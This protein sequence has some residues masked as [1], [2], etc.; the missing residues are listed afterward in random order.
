MGHFSNGTEGE[1]YQEHYCFRCVHWNDDH[2]CP[3]WF[4]HELHVGEK[5]W[6][7]T[8][9]KLIPMEPKTFNGITIEF[10]GKC[11]TFQRNDQPIEAPLRPGQEAA[12]KEWRNGKSAAAR[13][14][15]KRE[16]TTH[17]L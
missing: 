15:A 1:M 13:P 5:D 12:L 10:S 7:P 2:G 4:L 9:D 11:Y 8:L 3:V 16:V 6:R 17:E 14:S